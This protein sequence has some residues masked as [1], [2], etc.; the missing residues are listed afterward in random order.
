MNPGICTTLVSPLISSNADNFTASLSSLKCAEQRLLSSC[1][2]SDVPYWA[3]NKPLSISRTHTP[4]SDTHTTSDTHQF[5]TNRGVPI[6]GNSLS[7]QRHHKIL[8]VIVD[9]Y[10]TSTSL[11]FKSW[12]R[13]PVL[14]WGIDKETLLVTYRAFIRS[15]GLYAGLSRILE[16]CIRYCI[17]TVLHLVKN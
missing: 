7:L 10:F 4:A 15:I 8:G 17:S 6:E 12:M 5:N 14:G 1:H 13:S 9:T 2:A 3:R 16:K 11:S